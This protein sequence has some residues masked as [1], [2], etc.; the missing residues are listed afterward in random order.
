MKKSKW[1]HGFVLML[2]TLFISAAAGCVT[3]VSE[4]GPSSSPVTGKVPLE[5]TF[6]EGAFGFTMR[7]PDDWVY[8]ASGYT[9]IFSGK[10]DTAAYYST[11]NIQ[12]LASI[13]SGGTY[14]NVDSVISD[15]KQQLETASNTKVYSEK[16]FVYTMEDGE[17]LT[18]GQF[19]A[20]YTY[21]GEAFKLIQV[22]VPRSDGKAFYAWAYTSP[23]GQ[24]DTYLGIAQAMLDSWVIHPVT[25]S[26][27]P[28]QYEPSVKPGAVPYSDDFNDDTS[29]WDTFDDETGWAVYD[30]GWLHVTNYTS[31]EDAAISYA[32]QY[33]ADFV[34]EVETRFIDGT[35]DNWHMIGVRVD[36]ASNSSYV[37]GISADGYYGI[38]RVVEGSKLNLVEPTASIDIL[39][40]Q[41]VT[42]L[43]RVECVGSTLRMSVNGH[44]LC[45]IT[46]SHFED[47]D[48]C[49]GASSLGG[50]FTHVAFDNIL[51]TAP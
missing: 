28:T 16:T 12:N 48:I 31:A 13:K 29:G 39:K 24:F 26:P 47:G 5:N 14:E 10:K 9:V 18:G 42:N 50:E 19:T 32:H 15:F 17:K 6:Q 23:I 30:S 40:G 45:E 7:Y 25:I 35:D 34:L 38:E 41:G 4:P 37:F 44:L 3:V 1:Y 2:L 46:D 43:I 27:Q 49:L 20:E 11:V 33:F 8:E 21:Q 22:A 51:V 36:T